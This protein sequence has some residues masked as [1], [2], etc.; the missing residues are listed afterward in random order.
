MEI[1]GGTKD[2]LVGLFL[3]VSIVVLCLFCFVGAF[4]V[5]RWLWSLA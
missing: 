2:L 3:Y 4:T 1:E 5:G